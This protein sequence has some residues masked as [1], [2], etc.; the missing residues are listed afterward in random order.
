MNFT[1]VKYNP[2]TKSSKH[3]EKSEQICAFNC[4]AR[5]RNELTRDGTI[6]K[7]ILHK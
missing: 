5:S 1:A 7:S 2:Q 6:Q 4:Y 3:F